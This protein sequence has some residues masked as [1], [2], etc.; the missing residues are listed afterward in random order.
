VPGKKA[1]L[2]RSLL[3]DLTTA[4]EKRPDLR[5][6]RSLTAPTITGH[7]SRVICGSHESS[8]SFTR[9]HLNAAIACAY[10]DGT[11]EARRRF[12]D[13]R[14]VLKEDPDGVEKVVRALNYLRKQHPARKGIA[15]E[16]AYFRNHRHRM[17]YCLFLEQGLPIGSGVCEAACKTLATQRL[18]QSGMRWGE[19]GGQAILTLRGWT[20]SGDRFDRA[21]ALLAATYQVQVTTLHNVI[22]FPPGGRRIPP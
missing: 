16:L 7:F 11:I 6:V 2:K 19:E 10:G 5:L 22:P 21:W 17:R 15:T 20:Q 13:L 4:L 18:K 12:A 9:P 14:L 1:T 8:T 3:A